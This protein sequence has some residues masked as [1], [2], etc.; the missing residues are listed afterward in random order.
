MAILLPLILVTSIYGIWVCGKFETLYGKDPKEATIDEFAGMWI[1]LILV[2][3]E[4]VYL[5]IAFFLWRIFDIIKPPPARNFE[6]IEGGLGVMADDIMSG[7]YTL[8]VMQVIIALF[9]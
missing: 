5:V 6:K 1:S 8:V 3:K 2:P 4:P 7:I 9:K